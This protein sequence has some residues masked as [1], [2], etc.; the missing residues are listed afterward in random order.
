MKINISQAKREIGSKESF[1]FVGSAQDVGLLD[2][3][4]WLDATIFVDG[5]VTNTGH[6]LEIAGVIRAQQVRFVCNRCLEEYSSSLEVPFSEE[7]REMT[8][9]K[10]E[11]D[12]DF[13]CYQG[14]EIDIT[15]LVRESLLLAEPLKTLCREDCKGL[16]L[17][18]GTNLNLTSCSC[19]ESIVDPRLAVLRQFVKKTEP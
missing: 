19:L 10:N 9:E 13:S 4:G 18:C 11:E 6:F 14:D 17:H 7:F 15:E 2:E 5:A 8:V 16:C 3:Q 12:N 1:S